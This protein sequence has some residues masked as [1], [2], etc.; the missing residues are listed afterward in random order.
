M[1]YKVR[2]KKLPTARTGQ[3]V[4]YGMY[5]PLATMGGKDGAK[6]EQISVSKSI[7]AV[8]KEKATLEAEGG[9][10]V[11]TDL[12]GINI[13]QHY[14][15]KGPR[16]AQ[17]GVP[18]SLPNGAFVFSDFNE[19]KIDDPDMLVK[20]GKTV[21]K[22]G[23]GKGFTPADIAKQYDINKYIKILQD[24]NSDAID[25]K[26]AELMIKNYNLKLGALG[27]AQEAKKGFEDGVPEVSTPYM[28]HV[29][30]TEKD[31]GLVPKEVQELAQ[32]IS[33]LLSQGLDIVEVLSNL[34]RQEVE[35][36]LI[37]EALVEAGMPQQEVESTINDV[38]ANLQN[39]KAPQQTQQMQPDMQQEMMPE[40]AMTPEMM[41]Y[42]GQT[43]RRLKRQEGGPAQMMPEPGM[44]QQDPMAQIVGIIEQMFAQGMDAVQVAS[45][46]LQQGI[47]PE[48]LL[49]IFVQM[50]MPEQ[51]ATAVIQ[52]VMSQG[53][54]SE[55]MDPSM[56]EGQGMTPDMM[57]A[58]D[59]SM[60]QMGGEADQL[61]QEVAQALQQGMAPE[62]VMQALVQQGVPQDQ[63][64][65]VI[66]QVMQQM[67]PMARYGME[68]GKNPYPKYYTDYQKGGQ[69]KKYQD[70]GEVENAEEEKPEVKQQTV[71]TSVV[72]TKYKNDKRYDTQSD[73]YSPFGLKK[74]DYIKTPSG[75]KRLTADTPERDASLTSIIPNTDDALLFQRLQSILQDEDVKTKFAEKYKAALSNEDYFKTRKKADGTNTTGEMWKKADELKKA[76]PDEIVNAYLDH[77]KSNLVL[78][79][80]G[81]NLAE[82]QQ[83]GI[84]EPKFESKYKNLVADGEKTISIDN[85]K[86]K[87]VPGWKAD[88]TYIAKG[89]AG[90]WALR[91]LVQA[92]DTYDD[93]LKAK[94]APLNVPGLSGV[95]DES[96]TG[97]S[98]QF[99]SPIDGYDH[100]TSA[101]HMGV[102][103]GYLEDV[104]EKEEDKKADVVNNAA[105]EEAQRYANLPQEPIYDWSP[106]AK[107]SAAFLAGAYF[108]R[109]KQYPWAPPTL[110]EYPEYALYDPTRAITAAG[111]QA[112]ITAQ[113]ISNLGQSAGTTDARLAQISGQQAEK[114]ANIATQYDTMNVGAIN[115]FTPQYA[116]ISNQAQARNQAMRKGIYDDTMRMLDQYRKEGLGIKEKMVENANVAD[117]S[118]AKRYNLSKTFSDY[119]VL[120][121]GRIVFTGQEK[122]PA[123]TRSKSFNDYIKEYRTIFKNDEDVIRAAKIQYELDNKSGK[124]DNQAYELTGMLQ[125]GGMVLGSHV[126]PFMFY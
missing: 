14:T 2:I 46:L 104:I 19:M 86:K 80:L 78:K 116:N 124:N 118:A 54:P 66:E 121:D 65:M 10:T 11:M 32:M 37:S 120:P 16:H 106:Q 49:Q 73:K 88:K 33:T 93:N 81:V 3:Q 84:V 113:G 23:K 99:F 64:Q 4:N 92:K 22:G 68:T 67:Q 75:W 39:Q 35:L 44:E 45:E 74:G 98:Q 42:G 109:Q 70:E 90:Q 72:P 60:M 9:E 83:N 53:Q 79:A 61:M 21:K 26:T 57:P 115:S 27:L 55:M 87:N 95:S 13:P 25:K 96:G 108:N 89:Q 17:G 20:F 40:E 94:I 76:S 8:P 51:E 29:G 85:I 48:D 100:N 56:M 63:A 102:V 6:P 110:A 111:E 50:G 41:M 77:I 82:F 117:A 1:K 12:V 123:G 30:I 52:E 7:G 126:F 24:P 101:G 15:I 34:V 28:D 91:D 107:R 69:L 71:S 47:S 38:L 122:Q 59:P 97:L 114:A 112:A 125:Q 43:R 36:E 103:S 58:M 5:N 119:D 62:Q 18:M 31:L 105:A